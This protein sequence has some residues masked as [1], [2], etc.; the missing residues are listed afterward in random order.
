MRQG[1]VIDEETKIRLSRSR[2]HPEGK[3]LDYGSTLYACSSDI[4][5]EYCTDPAIEEV[6]ELRHTVDA[7]EMGQ[8]DTKFV[9][10]VKHWK[11]Y[12]QRE[13]SMGSKEGTLTFKVVHNGIEWGKSEVEYDT[14]PRE[15]R[16]NARMFSNIR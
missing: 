9:D 5:P 14:R 16:S 11:L 8:F 6:A 4:A 1:Q 2:A 7:S 13:V 3:S 10:G 12:Y 15:K